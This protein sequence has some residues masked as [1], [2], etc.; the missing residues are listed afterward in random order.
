MPVVF[1]TVSAAGWTTGVPPPTPGGITSWR[2]LLPP[3][4]ETAITAI[5]AITTA[6]AAPAT[7]PTI[8]LRRRASARCRARTCSSFCRADRSRCALPT[9]RSSSPI[10]L[11]CLGNI[12]QRTTLHRR[13]VTVSGPAEPGG[14]RKARERSLAAGCAS[15]LTRTACSMRRGDHLRAVA[16]AAD[17]DCGPGEHEDREGGQ[18]GDGK[19]PGRG[20]RPA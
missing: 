11:R 16:L 3:P 10:N 14:V 1:G 9:T 17:G 4:V 6:T 15:A 7:A 5:T 13:A 19:H 2:L 20:A 12:P 8:S 18:R